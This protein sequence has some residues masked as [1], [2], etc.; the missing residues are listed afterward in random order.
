M[1]LVDADE[2][3]EHVWRDK[4]DSRELIAQMIASAPPVKEIPT[5]IPVDV[6][7]R[8]LDLAENLKIQKSECEK[9]HETLNKIRSEIIDT[10]AYEQEVHGKTKFLDG[11]N[12]CLDVIEKY[13]SEEVDNI[14]DIAAATL[15]KIDELIAAESEDKK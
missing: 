12:Y 6:F 7:E 9:A 2:L 11:I 10:G 1:K 3:M 8:L 4:L 13:E 14:D 5:K 15:I